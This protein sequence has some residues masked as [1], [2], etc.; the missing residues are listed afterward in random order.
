MLQERAFAKINLGLKVLGKRADGYHE[1][2]MLM[3]SV[4]L[5]D[6]LEFERAAT[7]ELVTDSAQLNSDEQENLILKAAK[8]LAAATGYQGGAR[9]SLKKHIPIAAGLAGGS[10]DAAAAL[11]GLN[12]LWE[13]GLSM[14]ELE[15]LATQIGSDVAFCVRGGTQRAT[16]RGEVLQPV[17]PPQSF[18]LVIYKPEFNVSTASVYKAFD[19]AKLE[20][21][22]DIR[23]LCDKVCGADICAAT[24]LLGNDL[25]SVTMAMHPIIAEIKA[26]MRE[27]GAGYALMSGS[28]PSVFAICPDAQTAQALA[29]LLQTSYG[30]VAYA[31]RA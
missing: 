12:R 26:F 16:G 28:G 31:V 23:A 27:H 8:V 25:E 10:S 30:G 2:D 17:L 15:G 3:Q 7:V 24:E 29:Q 1:V 5:F 18:E 11:R 6:V 20:R 13:T 4:E 19:A 9:I 21:I 22:L 14:A